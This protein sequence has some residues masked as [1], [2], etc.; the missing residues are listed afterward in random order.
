MLL[1][2]L[3]GEVKS[4]NENS[5]TNIKELYFTSD[6]YDSDSNTNTTTM[7][8]DARPR[9]IPR[10]EFVDVIPVYSQPLT[11]NTSYLTEYLMNMLQ[12]PINTTIPNLEPVIVRPT[13][14][15]IDNATTLR[16]A[17]AIDEDHVCSICQENYTEGQAIRTITSCAH[18]F[19]KNCIDVWFGRNVHCPVCRHD[20]RE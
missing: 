16:S 17:M 20:I 11:T 15:Q 9:I 12:M 2:P 14:L 8:N 6:T 18:R 1:L 19:H 10:R 5:I 4:S 13:I 7:N 3:S